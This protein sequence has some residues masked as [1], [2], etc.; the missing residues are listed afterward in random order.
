M[1][2][3]KIQ[4]LKKLAG[5]DTKPIQDIMKQRLEAQ[6]NAGVGSTSF[7]ALMQ[8]ID[9]NDA[10]KVGVETKI[11]KDTEKPIAK[12]TVMEEVS[13]IGNTIGGR[14]ENFSAQKLVNSSREAAKTIAQR[15]ALQDPDVNFKSSVQRL[16]KNRLDNIDQ[17]LQVALSKVGEEYVVEP[18]ETK[19]LKPVQK[20]LN[21]LTD[22]QNSLE[23]L[24]ARME[25]MGEAGAVMSPAAMLTV[26]IKVHTITREIEFFTSL[27]SKAI[28][29]TKTVM[30]VQV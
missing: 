26:Q 2:L 9:K 30:N 6:M 18:A 13:R 19:G 29:S 14:R 21:M 24:G 20:F 12:P 4:K 25:M 11:E 23:T 10:T 7:E 5:A 1:A 15:E 28:E 8:R 27:L 17:N 3:D 16:L 22:S